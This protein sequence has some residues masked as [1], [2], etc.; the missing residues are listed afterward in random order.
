LWNI[1]KELGVTFSGEEEEMI[2]ELEN[3][4]DRDRKQGRTSVEE[5]KVAHENN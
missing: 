5:Q 2:K 1:A 4:E 3:M